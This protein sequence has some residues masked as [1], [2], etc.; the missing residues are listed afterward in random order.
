MN[1]TLYTLEQ[2]GRQLQGEWLA[3]AEHSRQAR[4]V[5]VSR[6]VRRAAKVAATKRPAV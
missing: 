5:R 4:L 2:R 3:N 1:D 6:A